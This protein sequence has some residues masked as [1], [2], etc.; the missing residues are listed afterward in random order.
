MGIGTD[1]VSVKGKSNE[2]M[3]DIGAGVGIAV[4]AVCLLTVG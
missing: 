3:D 1:A 2:R 4:H